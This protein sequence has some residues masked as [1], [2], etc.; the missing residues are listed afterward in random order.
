MVR[1]QKFIYCKK[2][3]L[4]AESLWAHYLSNNVFGIRYED[5]DTSMF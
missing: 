1:Y 3:L 4:A 2:K 5:T